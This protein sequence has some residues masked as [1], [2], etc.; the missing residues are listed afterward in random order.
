MLVC[1]GHIIEI[2][3]YLK[4]HGI[5]VNIKALTNDAVLSRLKYEDL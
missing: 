4:M 3:K 1:Q 5:K 2:V